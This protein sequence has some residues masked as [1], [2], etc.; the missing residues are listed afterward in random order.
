MKSEILGAASA[1]ASG[2]GAFLL[3]LQSGLP[4]KIQMWFRKARSHYETADVIS[5]YAY[6]TEQP[7]FWEKVRNCLAGAAPLLL[8]LAGA[9]LG[10]AAL[11]GRKKP[12]D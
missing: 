9:G 8:L 4:Q 11:A 12:R 6:R 10:L 3:L 7:G 5:T 2:T 1:L